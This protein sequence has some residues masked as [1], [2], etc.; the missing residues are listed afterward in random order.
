MI[1]VE[2]VEESSLEEREEPLR[3]EEVGVMMV[4]IGES[5]DPG[6]TREEEFI[7]V[8]SGSIPFVRRFA[9]LDRSSSRLWDASSSKTVAWRSTDSIHAIKPR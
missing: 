8:V 5:T 2:R 3:E 6:T 9:F 1:S 4:G 7:V